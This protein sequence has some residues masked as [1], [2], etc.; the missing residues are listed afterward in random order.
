MI[1]RQR[2]YTVESGYFEVICN[3]AADVELLSGIVGVRS[4]RQMPVLTTIRS[5]AGPRRPLPTTL[6]LPEGS[7]N[8][9][10]VVAVIDSGVREDIPALNAWVLG[11]ES[12]VAPE[13]KNTFH[14]TFV[15]GL[16]AFP[17]DLNAGLAGI[18]ST[19]CAVFDV[20]VIPNGDPAFGDVDELLESELLQ[21]CTPP[22]SSASS[23]RRN[24]DPLRDPVTSSPAAFR[25]RRTSHHS[26]MLCRP[27]GPQSPEN[28]TK[29]ASGSVPVP[30]MC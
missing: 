18:D 17:F 8:Q 3:K 5:L 21:P 22:P 30:P 25:S 12:T 16:V 6:P 4:V 15:A 11:R 2:G 13:Y 26:A 29:C 10:P 9:Y 19:P 20:Q 14:G 23:A 27:A 7:L 24:P 28:R 1:V